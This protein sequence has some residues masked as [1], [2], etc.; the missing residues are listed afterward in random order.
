M[1]SYRSYFMALQ[2]WSLQYFCGFFFVCFLKQLVFCYILPRWYY[3]N[4]P[5][6]PMLRNWRLQKTLEG[7]RLPWVKL[8]AKRRRSIIAFW[9]SSQAGQF[10]RESQKENE[11][12]VISNLGEVFFVPNIVLLRLLNISLTFCENKDVSDK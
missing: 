6:V 8:T 10:L 3:L 12:K 7:K 4:H 11:I 1:Q 2:Q 9:H 5:N